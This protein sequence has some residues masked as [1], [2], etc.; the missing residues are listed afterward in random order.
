M[1]GLVKFFLTNKALS[2]LILILILSGG[3]FAYNNMDVSSG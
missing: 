2:W 1:K 3:I